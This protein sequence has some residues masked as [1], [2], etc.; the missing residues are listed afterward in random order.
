MILSALP[1][2]QEAIIEAVHVSGPMGQRLLDFGLTPQTPIRCI[3]HS[4]SGDPSAYLIR[5]AVLAIRSTESNCICVNPQ[6]QWE[7]H[8]WNL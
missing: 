5:G 1:L 3:G 6:P 2:H 8:P 4:P 7:V